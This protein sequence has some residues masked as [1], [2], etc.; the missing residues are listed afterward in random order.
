MSAVREYY[1]CAAEVD[2]I[3][4]SA[5]IPA[6]KIE[7]VAIAEGECFFADSDRSLCKYIPGEALKKVVF[8]RK[9]PGYTIR[10]GNGSANSSSTTPDLTMPKAVVNAVNGMK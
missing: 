10:A 3:T 5:S 2:P 9:Y 8:E 6:G 4:G 1:A 7:C